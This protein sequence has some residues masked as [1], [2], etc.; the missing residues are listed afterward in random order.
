MCW[1]NSKPCWKKTGLIIKS[2]DLLQALCIGRICWFPKSWWYPL[3]SAVMDDHDLILKQPCWRLGYPKWMVYNG[4][5]YYYRNKMDHFGLP[6]FKETTIW[7]FWA[8]TQPP[9]RFRYREGI[10]RELSHIILR[11][12]SSR[13]RSSSKNKWG[14]TNKNGHSMDWNTINEYIKSWKTTLLLILKCVFH[15]VYHF[16]EPPY[17]PTPSSAAIAV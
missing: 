2:S 1:L 12:L 11:N 5:S 8:M 4:S 17:S 13:Q 16:I 6:P 10:L 9:G 14:F 7:R 3:A 15:L